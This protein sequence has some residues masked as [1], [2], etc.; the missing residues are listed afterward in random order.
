MVLFTI[1]IPTYNRAG[2]IGQTVN[3][4]LEQTHFHFELIIVDDGST[5]STSE[6]IQPYL[7]DSR[8]LYFR[9]LNAERGAARNFGVKQS[10]GDYI[11]FLDSD[12]I[13]LPWHF[14]TANEKILLANFPAAFHLAYE[15]LSTNGKVIPPKLLPSPV[16]D[17][18]IEGNFLSCM[19]VFLRKDVAF[20]NLF[21]EDRKLSG[22]EDYELWM[23]LASRIPILTYRDVTS[24]LIQHD[25]RSVMDTDTEKLSTRIYLLEDKLQ[26]DKFFVD[27]FSNRVHEFRAYNA[28]YLA[29]H[30]TISGERL[31]ALKKLLYSFK[32]KARVMLTYRFAVVLKK[33]IFG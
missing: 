21:D 33:I 7:K 9:I 22:S 11:T 30:L 8:V 27:R 24:R 25:D 17:K 28:L 23:R 31:L 12:D 18:L 20:E 19:G 26:R 2:L 1:I 5:D 13:L 10:N 4:V 14:Q 3:S 6:I 32:Q 15:I 16:N 29:L